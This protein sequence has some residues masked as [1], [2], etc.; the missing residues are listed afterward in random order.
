M[1]VTPEHPAPAPSVGGMGGKASA[2]LAK[3]KHTVHKLDQRLD[4]RLDR[5]RNVFM[6][7]AHACVKLS[8]MGAAVKCLD[9]LEEFLEAEETSHTLSKHNLN[10][11]N[12]LERQ[13]FTVTVLRGQ[14]LLTRASAK[15]ADAFVAVKDCETGARVF[16]SRTVL[17]TEDPRWEQ[18]F[19]VSLSQPK[20]LELECLDRQLVGKHDT[21]GS[22][23][24]T[25]DP[26]AFENVTER[27]VILTLKPRGV[28]HLRIST[29]GRE[30][31][32]VDH[33]LKSAARV[34][35][36][37]ASDMTRDIVD[38]VCAYV[39]AQLSVYA[40][41]MV[42]KPLKDKK[43]GRIALSDEEVDASISPVFT[44]LDETVSTRVLSSLHQFSIFAATLTDEVRTSVTLAIWERLVDNLIS[45]LIPPLSSKPYT[46]TPL[47]PPEVDVVFKWLQS[48]K[49]FFIADGQGI[50]SSS[51]SSGTYRDMLLLGQCL[52]LPT[53]T[54]KERAA[55]AVRASSGSGVN[56]RGG[57]SASRARVN[58]DNERVAEVLLRIVRMRSGTG[59]FLETQLAALVAA[60]AG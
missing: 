2:W 57:L 21:I 13:L 18:G 9:G 53:Q 58:E 16:K 51:L 54:L 17:E 25:I 1:Q 50:P 28:I 33:H 32:D 11:S 23:T 22:R 20:T 37:T 56:L 8:N 41:A 4:H 12:R 46:R 43:R 3:G 48:L 52:D 5:K 49:S 24:F 38:S 47:S 35:E 31:H 59:E 36:R 39:R 15:P 42:V 34:L 30:R 26:A 55:A 6:V 27:D 45:L 19:E 10:A 60:K 29:Q 40:L 7:P 44:Y 14:N